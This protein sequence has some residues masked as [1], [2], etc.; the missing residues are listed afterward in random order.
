MII[1]ILEIFTS[2]IM[3]PN[4]NFCEFN[5]I[6][7]KC[8]TK[9]SMQFSRSVEYWFHVEF[10]WHGQKWCLVLGTLLGSQS[11][12]PKDKPFLLMHISQTRNLPNSKMKRIFEILWTLLEINLFI[13]RGVPFIKC[14][15]S[16]HFY[17]IVEVEHLMKGT[18][19]GI[20]FIKGYCLLL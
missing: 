10:R 18:P 20:N 7:W 15:T 9:I 5:Y 14:S 11:K 1:S 13:P 8:Q 2:R 12:W 19:L 3:S 17:P 6:D 16:I 4:S